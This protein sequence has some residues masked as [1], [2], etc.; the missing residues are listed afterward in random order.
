M[1][2]GM[3]IPAVLSV[4]F[5]L[6]SVGRANQ[7]SEEIIRGTKPGKQP[8]THGLE[9][10][11][12]GEGD[13]GVDVLDRGAF[14]GETRNLLDT[15][16]K[17]SPQGAALAAQYGENQR[18]REGQI[19]WADQIIRDAESS[20]LGALAQQVGQLRSD[21][22]EKIDAQS[23][24]AAAARARGAATTAAGQDLTGRVG[25]L[26][27]ETQGYFRGVRDNP[28]I[29]NDQDIAALTTKYAEAEQATAARDRA[30]L[31]N[32]A[33]ARGLSPAAV[34]QLAREA[35]AAERSRIA[36]A[37]RDIALTNAVNRAGRADS[38]A[39]SMATLGNML[40]GTEGDIGAKYG[41]LAETQYGR[42]D[43]IDQWIA[44]A[45]ATLGDQLFRTEA[46]ITGSYEDRIA[47]AKAARA[48]LEQPEN[49]L[50]AGSLLEDVNRFNTQARAGALSGESELY[51]GLMAQMLGL[52]ESSRNYKL[53]EASQPSDWEKFW[54]SGGNALAGVGGNLA[55]LDIANAMGWL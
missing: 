51:A 6:G 34:A 54:G 13:T 37:G 46:G 53:A 7:A 44:E 45:G 36:Q 25:K 31:E 29:L 28:D 19:G 38:A 35:T 17:Y 26:N 22:L 18:A 41:A 12:F 32:D 10:S 49:L 8:G 40:Y 52:L 42:G 5:G 3:D 55:T 16:A 15:L 30:V 48:N 11:L 23:A 33:A 39:T 21:T 2:F 47:Q 27:E 14:A 24:N 50:L 9:W 4:L 1:G 20:R 43:A